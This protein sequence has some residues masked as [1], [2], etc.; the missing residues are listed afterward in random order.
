MS[1][2]TYAANRRQWDTVEW[3]ILNGACVNMPNSSKWYPVYAAL[4]DSNLEML[5]LFLSK[6]GHEKPCPNLGG[7]P[8]KPKYS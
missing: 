4:E 1:P 6:T 7:P 2:L 8:S 5:D 3:L